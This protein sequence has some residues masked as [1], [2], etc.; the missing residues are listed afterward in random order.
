[1]P[2]LTCDRVNNLD[3][4]RMKSI[5]TIKWYFAGMLLVGLI[6]GN[7]QAKAKAPLIKNKSSFKGTIH[8]ILQPIP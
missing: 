4:V 2:H 3:I 7:I 5:Q 6:C 1:M 8:T